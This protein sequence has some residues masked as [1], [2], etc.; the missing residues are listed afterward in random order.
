MVVL[1]GW[2]V[3]GVRNIQMYHFDRSSRFFNDVGQFLKD[4]GQSPMT[5]M[6]VMDR[7]MEGRWSEKYTK[8][9]SVIDLAEF[10]MT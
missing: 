6:L 1:G 9:T 3:V 7:W 8:C 5:R 4:E 2:K 10:S